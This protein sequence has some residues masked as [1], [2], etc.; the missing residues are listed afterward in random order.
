MRPVLQVCR[1]RRTAGMEPNA[2]EKPPTR[3]LPGPDHRDITIPGLGQLATEKPRRDDGAEDL[4]SP[5]P[6][7]EHARVPHQV[8]GDAGPTPRT[9][10]RSPRPGDIRSADDENNRPNPPLWNDTRLSDW[11]NREIPPRQWIT[12]D[13]IPRGQ[14]VGI[15]GDA[16]P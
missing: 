12:E 10:D 8:M 3:D 16:R 1:R 14:C 5:A 15:Y 6:D 13:W 9:V 2:G 7:R 11:A 4:R